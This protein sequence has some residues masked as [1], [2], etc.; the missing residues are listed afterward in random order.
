MTVFLTVEE[1]I[2]I[3]DSEKKCALR[4]RGLLESAVAQPSMGMDGVYFYPSIYLQAAVLLHRICQ[5]QAFEDANKRTAWLAC[6]T[7]LD[8]NGLTIRPNLDQMIPVKWLEAVAVRQLSQEDIAVLLA[9]V[10]I[11]K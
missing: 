7:F 8:L 1:V 6:T 4:D 9:G 11:P 2:A 5:A 3:H 10:V